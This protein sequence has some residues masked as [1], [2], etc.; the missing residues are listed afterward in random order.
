[1][2]YARLCAKL[3]PVSLCP[4]CHR[5]KPRRFCPARREKICAVCCGTK[6]L[7]EI[8]CPPDCSYLQSA[9]RHPAAAV[10]R[11][12]EHDLATLMATLG[13][14]SER[15]LHLFFLVQTFIARFTPNGLARL[16]DADVAEAA[17]ALAATYETSSRGVIYEHSSTSTVA[18]GLRHG[19][20]PFLAELG[21]G[22]GS[23]FERE[24][25]EVLRGIERGARHDAPSLTA[26]GDR[27]YLELIARVVQDR[28]TGV[29]APSD[30]PEGGS[31]LIVP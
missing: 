25:A 1:M 23:R 27:A 6:R 7:V 22:G 17:G 4:L 19:L 28:R 5:Q 2:R 11:Q 8:D 20:Q 24:A 29:P 13:R 14:V 16:I 31:S 15:Q 3:C 26:G 10:K 12:Q 18:E 21:R 30:Q 9:E